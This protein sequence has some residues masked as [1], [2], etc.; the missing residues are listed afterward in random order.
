MPNAIISQEIEVANYLESLNLPLRKSQFNHIKHLTSG[1]INCEASKN[2]SNLSNKE[3]KY[4]NQSSISR[5]FNKSNWL[6]DLTNQIR[7]K[8][9][10]EFIQ[11]RSKED[12]IGFLIIDDTLTPK[13]PSVKIEGLGFHYS[14]TENKSINAHCLT[15][16]HFSIGKM[17]MPIDFKLYLKNNYCEKNNIE[18]KTRIDLAQNLINE[19]N[20]NYHGKQKIYIM[21]DSWY[22]SDKL[23]EYSLSTG[24]HYIGGVPINHKIDPATISIKISDFYPF[25]EKEDLEFIRVNNDNY[26]VY[27]HTGKVGKVK[28]A[29]ILLCWKD[30][31]SKDTKPRCILS[32]DTQL[33]TVTILKNYS[34]RWEIETSF[35]YMKN[36]LG[37]NDYRIHSLKGIIRFWRI[38]YLA[39]NYLEILRIISLTEDIKNLGDIIIL[40][41]NYF[42]KKLIDFVYN[43]G[44]NKV[45]I[46]KLYDSLNIDGK[47]YHLVA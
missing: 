21:A 4:R 16:S 18:F 10:L 36:A 3:F 39:Y 44:K 30:K 6:D 38:I 41:R 42:I 25:I 14:H 11:S 19:F 33:D 37:L 17:S 1:I 8:N 35:F 40:V 20:S 23:I 32:T 45:P 46:T 28:C 34:K 15:A 22:A 9:N 43:A 13:N 29:S 31:F 5:F 47:F 12:D 27:R 26:Y 2:I 24:Y 7:I